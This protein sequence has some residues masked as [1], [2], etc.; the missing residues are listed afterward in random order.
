VVLIIG[1]VDALWITPNKVI[2]RVDD[3][4]ITVK[5]YQLQTRY[6]R[7]MLMNE[8][9]QINQMLP[10]YQYFGDPAMQEQQMA[11]AQSISDTLNQPELLAPEV[12]NTMIDEIIIQKKAAELNITVDED[13]IELSLQEGFG[14]FANGTATPQIEAGAVEYP[15]L[16]AEQAQL[17]TATPNPTEQSATQQASATEIAATKIA[18]EEAAGT[19]TEPTATLT[20]VPEEATAEEQTD[21]GTAP[22]ATIEPTATPYTFEL[23]EDNYAK[24]LDLVGLAKISEAKFREIQQMNQIR[25]LVFDAVTAD[26]PT[27]EEQVWARHILT[28]DETVATSVYGM[29][30][31][32]EMSF[33][34]LA[35]MFSSDGSAENGGDLGWFGRGMMVPEFED[36]AFGLTEVGQFTEPVESQF[37]FHIIQL[38][39]RGEVALSQDEIDAKKSNFFTDWL[40]EQRASLEADG[41][42][43]IDENLRDRY[44]PSEPSFNDPVIF[45]TLFGLTQKDS[46]QTAAANQT[47]QAIIALTP[48]VTPAP[49]E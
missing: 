9:V 6:Y 15:T 36:A 35:R 27:T 33:D 11:R 47:E 32:G 4:E 45:E 39:G 13:A 31:S 21:E 29:L 16:S 42:I 48:S 2:A 14:Y 8:Y 46:R 44:A 7:W 1:L 12:L 30:Q 43:T 3:Q 5:E 26:V 19:E 34:Q 25:S 38:L 49:S 18:E 10:Y 24:Y 40:A 41:L 17:V 23:Y 22:T 28:N 20:P 37:G